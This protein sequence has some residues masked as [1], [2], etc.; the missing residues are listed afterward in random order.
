MSDRRMPTGWLAEAE[1]EANYVKANDAKFA[2]R[3]SSDVAAQRL[4][5]A[6]Q[7]STTYALCAVAEELGR[8]RAA[9]EGGRP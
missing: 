3:V 4:V 6:A 2:K 8:I 9:L 5:A 7:L 1:R